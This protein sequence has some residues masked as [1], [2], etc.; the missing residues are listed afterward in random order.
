[1][2]ILL[3]T[4]LLPVVA[5]MNVQNLVN[6]KKK[7]F[8]G[9]N[10]PPGYVPGM[11]RGAT[12]FTTRSDIGP[13]RDANDISDERHKNFSKGKGGERPPDEEE[14]LNDNNYDEFNGNYLS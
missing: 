7:A 6:V 9:M 4:P 10:A 2:T 14:D 11:G 5:A 13:A 8:I 3:V 12:G 1:M